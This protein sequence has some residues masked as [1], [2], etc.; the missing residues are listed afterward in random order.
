MAGMREQREGA[1]WANRASASPT[2]CAFANGSQTAGAG[3]ASLEESRRPNTRPRAM[4][5]PATST[6]AASRPHNSMRLRRCC[7]SGAWVST[8]LTILLVMAGVVGRREMPAWNRPRPSQP[9]L[10]QAGAAKKVAWGPFR[11]RENLQCACEMCYGAG[12]ARAE[13]G[14]RWAGAVAAAGPGATTAAAG[15]TPLH[16]AAAIISTAAFN[17]W[18]QCAVAS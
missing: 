9:P 2:D 14:V 16:C 17:G 6:M 7:C 8:S 3:A 5:A 11:W 13:C 18:L 4:A 15:G 12:Q 1:V 10:G